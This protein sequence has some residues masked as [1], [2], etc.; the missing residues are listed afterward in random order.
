MF[1]FI[2]FCTVLK[3]SPFVV[4]SRGLNISKVYKFSFCEVPP[5]VAEAVDAEAG[6]PRTHIT[7]VELVTTHVSLSR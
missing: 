2:Y 5:A 3:P 4:T 7:A 1:Y 6:C